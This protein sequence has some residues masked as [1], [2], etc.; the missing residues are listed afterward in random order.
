MG[1]G[2]TG[3]GTR[4]R[5]VGGRGVAPGFRPPPLT[6]PTPLCTAGRGRRLGRP[7]PRAPPLP[8]P[9]GP[10]RAAGDGAPAGQSPATS[11]AGPA[12]A[13]PRG[14]ERS[15]G[16]PLEGRAGPGGPGRVAGGGRAVRAVRNAPVHRRTA[17]TPVRQPTAG[18]PPARPSPS[19]ARGPAPPPSPAAPPS[20]AQSATCVRSRRVPRATREPGPP[21][22]RPAVA[23]PPARPQGSEARRNH[24]AAAVPD[25]TVG[26][27]V[28]CGRASRRRRGRGGPRGR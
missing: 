7:G 14:G 27:P 6:L 16:P 15:E 28:A 12:R 26:T 21:R 5:L 13:R 17:G 18:P 20:E 8:L 11:D 3:V 23:A 22:S 1:P 19:F 4:S 24:T 25:A 2:A 9:T 10:A